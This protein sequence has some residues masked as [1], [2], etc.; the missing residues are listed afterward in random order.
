MAKRPAAF[1]KNDRVEHSKFSTGTIVEANERYTTV[2]FDKAGTK[3]FV[4]DMVELEPSDTPPPAKP[5]R[6]KRKTKASK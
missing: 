3:K 2:A 1:E 4:T 6:K 5:A